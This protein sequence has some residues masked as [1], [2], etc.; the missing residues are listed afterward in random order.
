MTTL[1]ADGADVVARP[2][3]EN[4]YG[5]SRDGVLRLIASADGLEAASVSV[6]VTRGVGPDVVPAADD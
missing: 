2:R 3:V 4:G 1:H 5:G 6:R